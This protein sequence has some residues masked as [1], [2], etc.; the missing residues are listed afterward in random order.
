[1]Y[2]SAEFMGDVATAFNVTITAG[3]ICRLR[4]TAGLND[5]VRCGPHG[6]AG[7]SERHERR[8]TRAVRAH[9]SWGWA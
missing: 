7:P 8:L 9:P 4:D 5:E 3:D 2:H 1:M 6:R